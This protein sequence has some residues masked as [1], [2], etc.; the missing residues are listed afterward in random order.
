ME[1]WKKVSCNKII[2]GLNV[3]VFLLVEFTGLSQDTEHML[4]WGAAYAPYISNGEY[5][6]LVTCMFLHFG[7]EH[8]ANNMLLLYVI[9]EPLER[10]VGRWRYLMI[11]F[12]G[13]IG[14]NI[15][16][17]ILEKENP[18]PP[19]SAGASGAVFAAVGGI[20]GVL[21]KNRGKAEGFTLRQMIIMAALSLY[22]GF[23][24]QGVDNA[25]HVGG[26]IL[27][28]ITALVCSRRKQDSE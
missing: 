22:F 20:I 10:A 5:Y 26:L 28:F 17:W 11:Y 21:V 2:I 18:M 8:L 19:V 4:N 1:N 12:V 13:G 25:A 7:M 14:G 9:G 6:R 15:L 24:S 27:G 3:L 16:S 23:A